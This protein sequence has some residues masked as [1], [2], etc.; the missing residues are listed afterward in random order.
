MVAARFDGLVENLENQWRGLAGTPELDAENHARAAARSLSGDGASPLWWCMAA[1]TRWDPNIEA[2]QMG[3]LRSLLISEKRHQNPA[4]CF[5]RLLSEFPFCVSVCLHP[6]LSSLFSC[7][8]RFTRL[9]RSQHRGWCALCSLGSLL[10][11]TLDCVTLSLF[12]HRS[13]FIE[14]PF[15]SV[16]LVR[17]ISVTPPKQPS[18]GRHARELDQLTIVLSI[19]EQIFPRLGLS[20]L[21]NQSTRRPSPTTN[22]KRSDRIDRESRP[23]QLT[24]ASAIP[25]NLEPLRL[26]AEH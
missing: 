7:S 8:S 16:L 25:L 9:L 1:E 23:R 2:Q 24:W 21:S 13:L 3:A 19:W 18:R 15:D 26:N 5:P 6:L 22:R 14:P 10:I 12:Y 4:S 17:A 11:P 20:I